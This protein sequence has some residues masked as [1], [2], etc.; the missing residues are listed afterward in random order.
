MLIVISLI[1]FY[2]NYLLYSY[3]RKL[4]IATAVVNVAADFFAATKRIIFIS[5]FY[6]CLKI[7][8]VLQYCQTV[9]LLITANDVL[10]MEGQHVYELNGNGKVV[11]EVITHTHSHGRKHESFN[12]LL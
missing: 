2:M 9:L 1:A 8:L 3:H 5:V 11:E 10:Y 6:F 4:D 12:E 7:A